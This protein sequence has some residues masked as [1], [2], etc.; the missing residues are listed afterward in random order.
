PDIPTWCFGTGRRRTRCC[1]RSRPRRSC[2][3]GSSG[4]C[5]S[6]TRP[7]ARRS[8]RARR[9]TVGSPSAIPGPA[10][11]APGSPPTWTAGAPSRSSPPCP[12]TGARKRTTRRLPE[13]LSLEPPKSTDQRISAFVEVDRDGVSPT[14]GAG[15]P[16]T[17]ASKPPK[18]AEAVCDADFGGVMAEDRELLRASKAWPVVEA[19]RLLERVEKA[20]PAK[21]YVLF[22]TGDRKSTR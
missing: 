18:D 12:P 1:R 3:M 11:S 7:P 15:C 22:E 13:F 19:V 10:P 8:A 2:P 21:G 5:R 4:R 14:I 17:T 20:P 6:G 9:R 16:L